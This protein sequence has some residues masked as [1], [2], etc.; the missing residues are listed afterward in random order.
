VID[1]IPDAETL[2][3][4]LSEPTSD[5][6]KSLTALDGDVMILGVAGKMG[7]SLARM[8]RRASDAAGTPRRVIGVARF[9]SPNVEESL[10][11]HR[12][13]TISCDLLNRAQLERLPEVPNVIS[14]VGRKFGST[15][16]EDLTWAVNALL[17]GLIAEKFHDSRIVAFST[18]NV[19]G[20]TRVE[21][22]GSK[23]TDAL[24]PR[25]EYAM[26]CVGRERLYEYASRSF[27]IPTALIRLN[28]AVEM[29]YGVLVDLAQNVAAGE[30]INL[31]MGFLNA[32]WQADAS[33]LAL[34]TLGMA[35]SPPFV[36]NVSGPEILRVRDV[37]E[38]L[39]HL[40]GKPARFRGSESPEALLS[41]T[42]EAQKLFGPPRVDAGTLI[43]W[44][45][46]WIARG[47]ETFG[48]PTHFEVR[49]GRF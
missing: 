30:T 36:L 29:R 28:Y 38:E 25:G 42:S 21:G 48:K 35:S 8:V 39:G 40:L 3:D 9:S 33:A 6:I 12:I 17:A 13:E 20:A 41:N 15:G 45:A 49:D 14:M 24:E 37:A 27:G 2:D 19:Y 16:R 5:V 43:R 1:R 34:Q 22:G 31:E 18:G 11:R 7:P 4:L 44:T 47:G 26:S 10:R 32:I 46:D 23:E